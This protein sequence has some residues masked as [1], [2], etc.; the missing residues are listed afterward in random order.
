MAIATGFYGRIVGQSGLENNDGIFVFPSTIDTDY[1][2]VIFV[3]LFNLSEDDYEVR[4]NNRIAQI[5][6][7]KCYAVKFI[8]YGLS[9]SEL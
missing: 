1:R 2:G 7:E 3:V 6:I 8:E 4:K 5:I 9:E